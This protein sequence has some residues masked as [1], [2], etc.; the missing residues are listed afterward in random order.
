MAWVGD[1][2]L[3][4]LPVEF[5][6]IIERYLKGEYVGGIDKM[7]YAFDHLLDKVKEQ[8]LERGR[9]QLLVTQIE[10]KMAKGKARAAIIDELELDAQGIEVLDNLD[11]YK[12]RLQ[13]LPAEKSA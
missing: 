4:K 8:N 1:V 3:E 10:T 11:E 13:E 12:K 5:R 6:G 7:T 2:L 9:L